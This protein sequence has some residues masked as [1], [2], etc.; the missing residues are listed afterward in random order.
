MSVPQYHCG[1]PTYACSH[2]HY[3]LLYIINGHDILVYMKNPIPIAETEILEHAIEA[4]VKETGI[5][6]RVMDREIPLDHSIIADAL[7]EIGPKRIE[8]YAE[9]KRHAQN[10]NIGA[11]INLIQRYPGNTVLVADYINPN[12][13]RKL[14]Q[15]NVQFFD[16]VGNAYLKIEQTYIFITGKKQDASLQINTGHIVN[17]AFEPKG[18]IVTYKFLTNP[19]SLNASYREIASATGVAVGT[20]GKVMSAL[21]AGKYI[22]E[23][24]R[25]KER[26]IIDYRKLLDRWVEAWPEKL[27]PKNFLG[28]FAAAEPN[29]WRDI[30]IQDHHGYWGGE[31]AGALYTDYLKPEIT[32]IYI[33]KKM[34]AKLIRDMR[35]VKAE[36]TTHRSGPVVHMYTPFWIVESDDNFQEESS[37]HLLT[38]SDGHTSIPADAG[39]VNP[40]LAYADLVATGDTRNLETATILY[41]KRIAKL[42]R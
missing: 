31:T 21:K 39:L 13:A 7:L 12:M 25:T 26:R 37:D 19:P 2:V 1:T 22:Q 24:V 27:K 5:L 20:V 8:I 16:A 38:Y 33:P 28:T 10:V 4:L 35:M 15:E 29:W 11:I 17:R 6:I 40:V 3:F 32:T 41:E 23:S 30:K 36:E 14:K 9:I 18:L 34:Q 42:N